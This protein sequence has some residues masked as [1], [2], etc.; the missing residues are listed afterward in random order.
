M[1]IMLISGFELNA[2]TT[3]VNVNFSAEATNAAPR[4]SDGYD[5]TKTTRIITFISEANYFEINGSNQVRQVFYGLTNKPLVSWTPD[6]FIFG[7]AN[8]IM[9]GT[10]YDGGSSFTNGRYRVSLD[11]FLPT[12]FVSGSISMAGALVGTPGKHNENAFFAASLYRKTDLVGYTGSGFVFYNSPMTNKQHRLVYTIDF[13]NK[14]YTTELN[15][16]N[17]FSNIPFWTGNGSVKNFNTISITTRSNGTNESMSGYD[18]IVMEKL[19]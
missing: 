7:V 19:P 18:N 1:L 8:R 11:L 3:Y 4:T 5:P 6:D 17:I 15:G 9:F 12:N 2:Q 16:T 10:Y 13:D 14:M